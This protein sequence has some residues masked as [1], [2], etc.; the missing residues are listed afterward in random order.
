M[1][2][3]ESLGGKKKTDEDSFIFSIDNQKV[4]K[5]TSP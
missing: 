2:S 5:V 4:Y 3:W 1:Q